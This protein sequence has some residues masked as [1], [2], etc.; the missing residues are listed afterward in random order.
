MFV[1][2]LC[3]HRPLHNQCHRHYS[4]SRKDTSL[5]RHTRDTLDC[6]REFPA[7]LQGVAF[8]SPLG[9]IYSHLRYL[10]AR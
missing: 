5:K 4:L 9:C 2:L 6:T 1:N 8:P 10:H 3:E 7:L